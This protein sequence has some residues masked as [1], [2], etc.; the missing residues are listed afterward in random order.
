MRRRCN[1]FLISYGMAN[2]D[3]NGALILV[4][5]TQQLGIMLIKIYPVNE[6]FIETIKITQQLHL[7]QLSRHT[8]PTTY[9]DIYSLPIK[10]MYPTSFLY[11]RS[12]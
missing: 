10:C 1:Q 11:Y 4:T 8:I 7:S 2:L 12:L 5:V 3:F 9:Q 6:F